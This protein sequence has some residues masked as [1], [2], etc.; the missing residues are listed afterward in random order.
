MNWIQKTGIKKHK[1]ALRKQLAIPAGKTIPGSLL[2][3]IVF[4]KA[5]Q[6]ITNPTSIGK[7][8]IKVTRLVE[9]RAILAKKLKGF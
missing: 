5:G 2:N 9:R 8:K 6:T 1:G 3:K 7:K 4:A